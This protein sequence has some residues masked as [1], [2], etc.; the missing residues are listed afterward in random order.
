M[1]RKADVCDSKQKVIISEMP[2]R[3]TAEWCYTPSSA[4]TLLDA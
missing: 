4:L 2:G 1:R 3:L